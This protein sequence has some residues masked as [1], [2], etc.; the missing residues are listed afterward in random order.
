MQD[1][2]T[3]ISTARLNELVNSISEV[4]RSLEV[5]QD[6][7]TEALI[8]LDSFTYDIQKI[9]EERNRLRSQVEDARSEAE[10]QAGIFQDQIRELTDQLQILKF[11]NESLKGEITTR[12]LSIQGLVA[13]VEHQKKLRGQQQEA[14]ERQ[15]AALE[16]AHQK[17][18]ADAIEAEKKIQFG[19]GAQISELIQQRDEAEV[20]LAAAERDLS[21][22]R[23]NMLG[24]L[25]GSTGTN[26]KGKGRTD[27]SR[28][29]K[30]IQALS[31]ENSSTVDDYLKRLGY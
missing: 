2:S 12:E 17:A 7:K 18:I 28:D 11:E 14:H 29:T 16:D 22:I 20:R 23:T 6:R 8:G 21:Q 1:A 25:Q 13:E 10:Q 5:F 4:R 9:E 24:I 31:Q 19:L 27:P 30:T 26:A 15:V 3:I